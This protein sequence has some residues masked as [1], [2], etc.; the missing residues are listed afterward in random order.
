VLDALSVSILLL[1]L[2]FR[3]IKLKTESIAVNTPPLYCLFK[4]KKGPVSLPVRS[5]LRPSSSMAVCGMEGCCG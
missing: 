4:E 2:L 5:D 1:L 3:P